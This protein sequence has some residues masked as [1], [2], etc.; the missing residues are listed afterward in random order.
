MKTAKRVLAVIVAVL[1]IVGTCAVAASAADSLQAQIDAGAATI[2]LTKNANESITVD[3]DIT[4]DL[5]GYRINGEYGKNAITVKGGNVTITD[6]Q[7][8]SN[9]AK[10]DSATM[11][12]T[13]VSQSPSAIKV[14]GGSVTLDGVRVVGG[15]TRIPTTENYTLPTG[16]ALELTN[17]ATATLKRTSLYGRYG[18]NNAVNGGTAGGTVA[19]EDALIAGFVKAVKGAYTPAEGSE[20]IIAADRITGVLND[21]ITLEAGEKEILDS[22]FDERIVIV[23]KTAE[24]L[25]A[26]LEEDTPLVT[27]T[28]GVALAEIEAPILDYTWANDKGTDCSYRLVPEA[29]QLTDGTYADL[30]SA[31]ADMITEDS[32][33]RYRVQF[34]IGAEAYPYIESLTKEGLDNPLDGVLGWAGAEANERY[35]QV[36]GKN[37][38]DY[39]DTYDE[40]LDTLGDLMTTV[41]ELGNKSISELL[42]YTA[43]EGSTQQTIREMDEFNTLRRALYDLAGYT[44]WYAKDSSEGYEFT[45]SQYNAIYGT[46]VTEVPEFVGT[47]DRVDAL[48]SQAEEI[49]GPNLFENTAAYGDLAEWAY[50][51]AYPELL[52]ILDDL[53]DRLTALQDLFKEEPYKSMIGAAG[54]AKEVK[55]L[56][57][58]VDNAKLIQSK[59]DA[60]LENGDVAAVINYLDEHE[61]EIATRVNKVVD[62]IENWRTYVTPEKFLVKDDVTGKIKYATAYSTRGPIEI[63][64]IEDEGNLHVTVNGRGCSVLVKALA[65]TV[66]TSEATLPFETSFELTATPAANYEFLFWVNKEGGGNGRIL[67]TEPTFKMTTDLDRDIE[68]VFNRVDTPKA[69]FTN[70]T[71]DICGSANVINQT[72][73]IGD[74]VKDPYVA[75]Y[76]FEGWPGATADGIS[77]ADASTDYCTGNS[78]FATLSAYYGE[79]GAILYVRPE[80]SGYIITPKYSRN[81]NYTATFIDGDYTWVA[82]GDYSDVA[83]YTAVYGGNYWVIDGTDTIVCVNKTFP[84]QMIDSG[85]TF[86]A[87]E[88]EC[89]VE[90]VTKSTVRAENGYAVFYIERSTSKT[91][92]QTGM[93]YSTTT[94]NPT[95]GAEGCGI[96]SAKNT[97]QTALFAP[98]VEISLL[99]GKTLYGRAYIEFTDGTYYESPDVFQYPG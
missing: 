78:A 92:K 4:I 67:T 89:P 81:G 86:R 51:T 24:T 90:T 1:M 40:L 94:S 45:A 30:D 48:K 32:Q 59:V 56:D 14:S 65:N 37:D 93:V 53:V 3:R 57:E 13:V 5:A 75:G 55:L 71:G 12:E 95:F 28:Q 35:A 61:D 60:A 8:L 16:S 29:I 26:E 27:K 52:E 76:G 17:G 46:S 80:S 98:S 49:L 50:V 83:T 11:I 15:L 58:G 73:V 69:Y 96:I 38:N 23:T 18:V 44:A 77:V 43:P 10:V 79:D 97:E 70:P 88:G 25:T 6:G 42:G 62:V 20:E 41:D 47:L 21:G 66:V 82:E 31:E 74:D 19:I 68:A 91:I 85:L 9:F 87:V 72:A 64:E 34:L 22:F 7:V 33:I 99:N 36:V 63:E 54:M 84:Y 39:V 2:T